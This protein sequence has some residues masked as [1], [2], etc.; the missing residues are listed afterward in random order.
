LTLA[1]MIG[2]SSTVSW[3]SLN[4]ARRYLSVW[5]RPK[6]SDPN[7]TLCE[8]KCRDFGAFCRGNGGNRRS[9][10]PVPPTSRSRSASARRARRRRPRRVIPPGD[11]AGERAPGGEGGAAG[12]GAGVRRPSRSLPPPPPRPTDLARPRAGDPP[13]QGI[14]QGRDRMAA[15]EGPGREGVPPVGRGPLA[16]ATVDRIPTV[17]APGHRRRLRG[18][19]DRR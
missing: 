12:C 13:D 15:T 8:A 10:S 4:R 11:R 9:W 6:P 1:R 2:P 18:G 3:A 16:P 5:D 17:G 14:D 7:L 19:V